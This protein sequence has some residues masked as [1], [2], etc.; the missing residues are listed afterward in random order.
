MKDEQNALDLLLESVDGLEQ[1]TPGE[2]QPDEALDTDTED[3]LPVE[4]VEID[5]KSVNYYSAEDGGLE[6]E[7]PEGFAEM[8]ETEQQS[9]M[10]KAEEGSKTLSALKK[11]RMEQRNKDKELD[12]LRAENEELR[13]VKPADPTPASE[14]DAPM[15]YWGVETWDD[16]VEMMSDNH[17]AYTKGLSQKASDESQ[18]RMK[19]VSRE[20]A[21][22][23]KITGEGFDPAEVQ[24]FAEEKGIASIEVAFDY[25]KL[26]KPKSNNESILRMR[27]KAPTTAPPGSGLNPKKPKSPEE[28]MNDLLCGGA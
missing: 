7:E 22:Q 10:R 14:D 9:F 21:L 11:E 8:S 19:S 17:A 12:R 27:K 28:T 15:K 6:F 25:F 24:R 4:T 18:E 1:P 2:N 16:V 26:T 13:K 5:G 20:A 3:A 23:A